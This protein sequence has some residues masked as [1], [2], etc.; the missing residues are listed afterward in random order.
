MSIY[1]QYEPVIGLEIHTQ[2]L[3]ESKAYSSDSTE[4]GVAPNTNISP[5]SLG[6]PGTLPV[7][8]HKTI[9]YA[10][11]LGTALNCEINRVNEFARK[12]Y[13]YADLPKGYQ[14]TQD[15]TPICTNGQLDIK[16]DG[17]K[18]N[19]GITRVHME[20]DSGK[21]MHDI[22]PYNTLIDL[23][24]AG[25][26]LLEI[27]SE[28]DLRS[29]EEAYAYVAEVRKIV[30]YLE[31]CDGNMEEGSMRCDA[32]ISVRKKGVEAF[33]TKV[34][35]KNM[36]SIRNVKRAIEHEIKRQID[37]LEAGE[38]IAQETRGFEPVKGTTFPMR[39]K[40]EANDYRY[41]P[42][43]DLPPVIVD[44]E[45]IEQVQA[46]MPKLP[47]VLFEKFTQ[48][49]SLSEYDSSVIVE[50]KPIAL[51]FLEWA[52]KIKDSTILSKDSKKA[53]KMAANWL[54]GPIK[55]YLNQQAISIADFPVSLPNRIQ[56]LELILENKIS[57]SIAEQKLLPELIQQPDQTPEQIAEKLN[58]IQDS[59][60]N[61]IEMWV[62]EAIAK[63]PEKVEEYK[64]GK[65]GLMGL[66]MGE[67]MKLSKGKVDPKLASQLLAK[68]LN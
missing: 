29:A 51:Y 60:S 54:L 67:V 17:K 35:V 38:N 27:V 10:I 8:N 37:A 16:L 26:P 49:Y 59:D 57:N 4:F 25:V 23:N 1:E 32:N 22:D 56:L 47:E 68:K 18:I 62:N 65:K 24:R 64:S 41:F 42:E 58:L 28:P 52:E 66:F 11:M 33:G 39:S 55:S 2:L 44:R 34:E 13:F 31:I 46:N 21:S 5:I 12:N 61:A 6:Y 45:W 30:R 15:T 40:E 7:M 19:I 48:E 63:Y 53:Y 36:N 3:T 43:P 9:D 14:I 50:S 20:E